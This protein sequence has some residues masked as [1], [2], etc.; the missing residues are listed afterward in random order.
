M[1]IIQDSGVCPCTHPHPTGGICPYSP[2]L[3]SS[4]GAPL[5]HVE[6]TW[7]ESTG[8]TTK[9]PPA[10]TFDMQKLDD[11]P[12]PASV[13]EAIDIIRKLNLAHQ[14]IPPYFDDKVREII[15]NRDVIEF[16]RVSSWIKSVQEGYGQEGE[17]L[18]AAMDFAELYNQVGYGNYIGMLIVN[19]AEKL[20]QSLS[21]HY[22]KQLPGIVTKLARD[23]GC[24][25]LLRSLTKKGVIDPSEVPTWPPSETAVVDVTT[26]PEDVVGGGGGGE[27]L[28]ETLRK[29]IEH[30]GELLTNGDVA[31][32]RSILKR[33]PP[34]TARKA[35]A[36]VP[37]YRADIVSLLVHDHDVVDPTVYIRCLRMM[38]NYYYRGRAVR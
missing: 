20:T 13:E 33:I 36:V 28:L 7:C 4:C 16:A 18:I 37:P 14:H 19:E 34:A 17:E 30:V 21:L 25:D 29:T 8:E 32:A 22:N 23:A 5:P 15:Q 26:S 27:L 6:P 38:E 2:E 3:C 31:G 1:E 9:Y 35:L 10:P 24:V 11:V 12:R